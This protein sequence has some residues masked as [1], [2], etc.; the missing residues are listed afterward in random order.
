MSALFL[1]FHTKSVRSELFKY[2]ELP[3]ELLLLLALLLVIEELR[4]EVE[5][6]VVANLDHIVI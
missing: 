6:D 5:H 4:V 2:I 3:L 1:Y